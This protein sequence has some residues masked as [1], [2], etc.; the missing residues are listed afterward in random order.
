MSQIKK[1]VFRIYRRVVNNLA[2]F[3]KEMAKSMSKTCRDY[4]NAIVLEN[5]NIDIKTQEQHV[6]I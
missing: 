4:K 5:F 3:L 6:I 2:P 1:G